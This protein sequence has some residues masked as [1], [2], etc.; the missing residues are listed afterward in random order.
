MDDDI[1]RQAAQDVADYIHEVDPEDHHA[2]F[3]GL[4][5]VIRMELAET[6]ETSC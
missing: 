6:V 5:T 1:L 3:K 4:E 2:V